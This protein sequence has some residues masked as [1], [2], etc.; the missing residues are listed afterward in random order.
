MYVYTYVPIGEIT[1]PNT[2]HIIAITIAFMLIGSII[3]FLFPFSLF[4]NSLYTIASA[5]YGNIKITVIGHTEAWKFT[6]KTDIKNK[7]I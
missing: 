1:L 4:F 7:I 2:M 6:I 5:K 3:N